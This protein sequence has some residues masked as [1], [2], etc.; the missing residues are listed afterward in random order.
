MTSEMILSLVA[1]L[2][3]GFALT[4]A[5]LAMRSAERRRMECES[6]QSRVEAMRR[7]LELLASISVRTGRRVQRVEHEFSGVTGRIELAESRAVAGTESL[8]LAI[9]LARR[10]ADPER[11]T[12]Q[13]GL[14]AGEAELVIR[15]HRRSTLN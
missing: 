11:L 2:A 1:V 13:F 15:L 6:L 8:D 14:S 4:A 10:G 7:E 5:L 9:D 12:E 3:A